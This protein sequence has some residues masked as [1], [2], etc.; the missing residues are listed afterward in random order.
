MVL[1]RTD[2]GNSLTCCISQKN[3]RM[4]LVS[5]YVKFIGFISQMV[6]L[7]NGMSAGTFGSMELSFVIG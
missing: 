6:A 1:K 2:Y 7:I 5:M 4:K 3:W